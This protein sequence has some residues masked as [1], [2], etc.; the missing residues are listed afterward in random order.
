MDHETT[1]V[2]QTTSPAKNKKWRSWV[3]NIIYVLI[4]AGIVFGIPATLSRVLNTPYPMAAI[5]S[6][7]M[8]PALKT[9]DL[10]FI[11]G[12]ASSEIKEGDIIVYRNPSGTSFTI[13][14]VVKIDGN[15]FTTKGDANFNEDPP[16]SGELIVGRTFNWG[17]A[18]L[19][20]PYVGV[21]SISVGEFRQAP[22]T[23]S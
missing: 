12:V 3:G 5:T 19:R 17:D 22:T 4:L 2:G 9:N 20:I 6:G 16:I 18:P 14:R 10:V 11:Q 15:T 21:I 7:S 13:H 23:A 8:W 1:T